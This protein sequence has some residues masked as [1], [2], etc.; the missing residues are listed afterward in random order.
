MPGKTQ[1]YC[2]IRTTPRQ[3]QRQNNQK[4]PHPDKDEDM[5]F[6]CPVVHRFFIVYLLPQPPYDRA[7]RPHLASRLLLLEHLVQD[8]DQP[9]LELAVVVV[10]DDEVADAVHASAT[11]ICAIEIKVGEVG[12]SQAFDKVLFNAASRSDEG[13]DMLVLDKVQDHFT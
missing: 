2:S 4:A 9:V 6:I 8:R 11:E 10:G 12:L 7:W 1:V 13:S 3:C 5:H